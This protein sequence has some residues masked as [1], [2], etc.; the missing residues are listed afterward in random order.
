MPIT[1]FQTSAF[2]RTTVRAFALIEIGLFK[3]FP[4]TPSAEFDDQMPI[5]ETNVLIVGIS[6]S[7]ETS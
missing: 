7:L 6:F 5:S 1:E 4:A 3:L 2:P